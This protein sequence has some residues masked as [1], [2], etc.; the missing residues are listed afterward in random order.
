VLWCAEFWN[1]SVRRVSRLWTAQSSVV[2]LKASTECGTES[3]R[4]REVGGSESTFAL[5][6]AHHRRVDDVYS[7]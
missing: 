2:V 6:E 4:V 5:C 7:R 3:T 1:R